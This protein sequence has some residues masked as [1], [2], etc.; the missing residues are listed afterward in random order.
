VPSCISNN[1]V[2]TLETYFIL[3]GIFRETAS[4]TPPS[5]G[6][7]NPGASLQDFFTWHKFCRT[8]LTVKY[9]YGVSQ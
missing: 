2:Y 3:R 1:M 9:E 6:R 7:V 5:P 8:S 4:P